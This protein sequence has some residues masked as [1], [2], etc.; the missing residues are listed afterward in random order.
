MATDYPTTIHAPAA[1]AP[2]VSE[3]IAVCGVCGVQ[4]QIQTI[5]PPYAD[6]K[7]CSFCD[8]PAKAITIINERSDRNVY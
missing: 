2:T 1:S 4:W 6:A 7:G 5:S 3:R 8:A